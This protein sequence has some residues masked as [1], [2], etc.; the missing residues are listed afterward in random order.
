MQTDKKQIAGLEEEARQ[1]CVVTGKHLTF[2][3]GGGL[4]GSVCFFALCPPALLPVKQEHAHPITLQHG[5]ITM[6]IHKI[7]VCN[8]LKSMTV[9]LQ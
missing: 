9:L 6:Y 1:S 2:I 4:K 5:S 8:D 7:S 3:L